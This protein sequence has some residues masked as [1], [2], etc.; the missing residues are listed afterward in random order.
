MGGPGP[1]SSLLES[2]AAPRSQQSVLSVKTRLAA[3]GGLHK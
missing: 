3:I 2:D 1:H